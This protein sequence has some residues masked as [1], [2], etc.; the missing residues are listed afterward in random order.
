MIQDLSNFIEDNQVE[1]F[2]FSIVLSHE[3]TQFLIFFL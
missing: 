1:L 2:P 3:D